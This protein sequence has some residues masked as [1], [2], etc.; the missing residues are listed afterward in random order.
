LVGIYD[1]NIWTSF[2]TTEAYVW[3]VRGGFY[4][5]VISDD[6]GDGVPDDQEMGPGAD[7]PT[8]DGNGDGV[9]DIVQ[10]NVGSTSTGVGDAYVTL[11]SGPGTTLGNIKAA[12]NPS[13][14]DAPEVDFPFGFFD[15]TVGDIT[16]GGCTTVT[17][18][19]PL[20]ASL[21]TYYKYGPEPGVPADHWYQFLYDGTTG[22]EI[23]HDATKTRIVLH[24]CDGQRGDDDLLANGTVEDIG[25][26]GTH[27][28]EIFSDGFE[29]GD[30]SR[31]STIVPR[32]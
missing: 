4:G 15:F 10:A 14:H 1:G 5:S 2:R 11:A 26:P 8:Y 9:P 20:D 29:G 18:H 7:D 28:A 31:W 32:P 3:P 13:P 16:V 6:D 19:L 30:T 17:L 27:A 12:P 23:F 22:A 24:L 25:G 21:A